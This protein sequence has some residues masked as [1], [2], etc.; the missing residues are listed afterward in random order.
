METILPGQSFLLVLL[1]AVMVQEIEQE[2]VIIRFQTMEEETAVILAQY[3][4]L[5]CVTLTLAPSQGDTPLG[6][7]SQNVLYLVA[8]EVQGIGQEIVQTLNLNMVG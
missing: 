8:T 4:K 5:R 3:P 7:N 2:L 6:L 1:L